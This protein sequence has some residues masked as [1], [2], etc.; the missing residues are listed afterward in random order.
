MKFLQNPRFGLYWK[1]P[2]FTLFSIL[3]F[4]ALH[5]E[6]RLFWYPF[7]ILF[8]YATFTRR[9]FSQSIVP[10]LSVLGL[11]SGII[12]HRYVASIDLLF[13]AR[14]LLFINLGFHLLK[15]TRSQVLVIY[16]LNFVLVLV[17]AALTFKFWFAP[18]ILFFL[19]LMGYLCLEI[20]FLPFPKARKEKGKS[21]Y[22]L[23]LMLFLVG[24]GYLFF[25][26]FPR[27]KFDQFPSE[28]G[29]S[30]SG[31]EESVTFDEMTNILQSDKVVM[32]VR[33]NASP[34]YYRGITLDHFDGT[35]WK[36]TSR[37]E[38]IYIRR[39]NNKG[40][41]KIP[42]V[43]KIIQEDPDRMYDFQLLPSKNKYL[44][45]PAN[46]TAVDI[47]PPHLYQNGHR[48]LKKN[49]TLTKNL[50]YKTF[51]GMPPRERHIFEESPAIPPRIERRYL[52]VPEVSEPVKKLA[53]V[54]TRGQSSYL[55]K[56]QAVLES[57]KQRG[58]VYSLS[59]NH[60]G[61]PMESFLL[62]NKVGHCQYYAGAMVLLLRLNGIPARVVNGFT[63][64][65]YNEWGDYYTIRLR[66]A[67]SWVEFW[68]GDDLWL[69]R[70]PTPAAPE[71]TLAMQIFSEFMAQWRK[72]EEFLDS[73]WQN[74]VLYFSRIDQQLLW[75]KLIDWWNKAPVLAS[76]SILFFFF[77]FYTMLRRF[78]KSFERKTETL[79]LAIFKLDLFL[80]K[81]GMPRPFN[82]ALK[83][84]LKSIQDELD[85][86]LH[87]KLRRLVDSIY[88][89]R[90]GKIDP[91]DSQKLEKE[92]LE[93]LDLLEN[94]ARDS[95]EKG[96]LALEV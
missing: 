51:V 57:F 49:Q 5:E 26:I 30:I 86:S 39:Y 25:L 47:T 73:Q 17:A 78:F 4:A 75:L 7:F 66:D 55:G 61:N 14:I 10:W 53:Q 36:N 64:G 28:L 23:K 96:K 3:P 62:R 91:E 74:Y 38:R 12:H 35:T 27:V 77:G 67:H 88:E 56:V 69:S 24:A 18:Y 15:V 45:L 80:K 81:A 68:A 95:K 92:I 19:F 85:E 43:P 31:F 50:E 20:Q 29:L 76:F 70:D 44:F 93:Q 94:T 37:F 41:L 22:A 87:T 11:I 82:K 9:S 58:Y 13:F 65:Q 34:T 72:I 42:R 21:K 1:T 84:H 16:F 6:S 40:A 83:E 46:T 54:I 52:Q 2:Y 71:G 48:D 8:S 79:P 89:L 32:R 60:P 63:S 33:T 59:S 90:Y